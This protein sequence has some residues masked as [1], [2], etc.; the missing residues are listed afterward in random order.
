MK[1]NNFIQVSGILLLLF[2]AVTVN[3]QAQ[4]NLKVY[5]NNATDQQ[6]TLSDNGKFYFSETELFISDGHQQLSNI[7]LTDIRKITVDESGANS[8][9][10]YSKRNNAEVIVYPNPSK[11]YIRIKSPYTETTDLYITSMNGQV[12]IHQRYNPEEMID[13]SRLAPGLYIVKI[14]NVTTKISKL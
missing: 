2:M 12:L 14:G 9:E 7:L 4:V 3:M 6:F 5:L 8:I 11:D 13:I 10:S 1:K